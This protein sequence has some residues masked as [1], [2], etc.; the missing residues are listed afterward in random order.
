MSRSPLSRLAV[1]PIV[2][3]LVAVTVAGCS[4]SEKKPEAKPDVP[5]GF[6]VPAGVTLTD[7][8]SDVAVGKVATVVYDP[9]GAASAVAVRIDSA[10]K[11]KISDFRF[12]SLDASTKKSTPYYVNAT[13]KN[14]G[15]A[16]LGGAT[17]PLYL[18]TS[19]NTVYPPNELVGTFKPCPTATL[20]KSFLPS[21][22]AK[23]CLVYLV[24]RG[25]KLQS[26]DL[27]PAEAKDAIHFTP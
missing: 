10:K 2:A 20:P 1:L 7:A 18:H 24:P 16:G 26:I 3:V 25:Q 27:Q 6:S 12:F 21:A 22:S 23:V 11:G 13:V 9:G 14:Q 15:P 17:V 8:G 19:A 5:K 4:S